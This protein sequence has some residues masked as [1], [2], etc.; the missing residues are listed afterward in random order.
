MNAS[1]GAG[2]LC[3]FTPQTWAA[4][5]Y[6]G[7]PQDAPMPVQDAAFARAFALYGTQPWSPVTGASKS[8]KTAGTSG[9]PGAPLSV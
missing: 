1:S 4:L 5:G 9:Q 8:Q 3:Q 2:G 7:L 6:G